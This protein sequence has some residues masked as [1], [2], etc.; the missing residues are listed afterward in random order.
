MIDPRSCAVVIID[1]QNGF[2]DDRSPLCIAGASATVPACARVLAAARSNG[3]AVVHAVRSY[4]A[5]GSD[6]E[7]CR[8]GV[9]KQGRPLSQA[10]PAYMNTDEPPSLAPC[11][12]D[13]VIVKPRFS[14]FF[15]TDLHDILRRRDVETIVLIGT[16]TPNC[17]RSSCYD[18]LSLGYNVAVVE[19]AT[20]SRNEAVQR[21]NLEDMAFIGAFMLDS[22]EFADRGLARMPDMRQMHAADMERC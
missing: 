12:D 6:V 15:A 22:Y 17:I 2:I 11:S 20:S 14:A 18:A 10:C 1:M 5:D 9:W 3:M 7:P 4:A 21:A 19:D 13:I 16:T 8:Y